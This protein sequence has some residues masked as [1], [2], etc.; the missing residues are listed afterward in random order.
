MLELLNELPQYF[1]EGAI[2]SLD[3]FRRGLSDCYPME[4]DPPPNNP[5]SVIYE[6]GK[7]RLRHYRARGLVRRETPL[8]MVYALIKRPF[9]L[10][11]MP[12]RSVV[13]TMINSGFEVYMI[14]W[15]PPSRADSWRGFDAYVNQDIDNAVRAVQLREG[16]EQISLLGY[17]F[18]GMLSTMYTALHQ[19]V[20]KNFIPLTLPLDM[21]VRE[22]PLNSLLDRITDETL[23]LIT[24]VYGN[25]PASIMKAGFTSMSPVHHALDKYVGLYR[26]KQS[27]G[28][29]EMFDLFEHWMNND[30]PLAGQI[31]RELA[32]DIGK[33]N[34]L[35][36]SR[37]VAGGNRVEL[38]D[39]NCPVLNVVA[40][41]D[42]VVD[43]K[44]SLPFID[45]ISS[46]D[47]ANVV[48]PTGHVGA[49]VSSAAQKKLWPQVATWL[50]DH[51]A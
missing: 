47:K 2:R 46:R 30:V 22:I 8:L 6:G 51:D 19:D 21:S 35:A 39:I 10:D 5:Y 12:G 29:A 42:D 26:N 25:C 49:V 27:K 20:I 13:E 50:G 16:V 15:I 4:D 17:C 31:F 3:G 9:I 43:P 44:S 14:D 23:D 7:V 34:L 33:K 48:F 28:Y 41:W 11:L 45:L 18:G 40:Q 32:N 24:K 37:F 38:K 1:M 36:Q